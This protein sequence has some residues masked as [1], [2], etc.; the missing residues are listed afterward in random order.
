MKSEHS[1][2]SVLAQPR[3]YAFHPPT[4]P[5]QSSA[6]SVQGVS[7]PFPPGKDLG[8]RASHLRLQQGVGGEE[9]PS[10]RYSRSNAKAIEELGRQ[11]RTSGR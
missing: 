10:H 6:A 8:E 9:Q 7:P 1:R 5:R 11:I 4:H 2:R 3:A